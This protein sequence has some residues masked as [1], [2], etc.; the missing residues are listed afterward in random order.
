MTKKSFRT[1]KHD[2]QVRPVYHHLVRVLESER[3][4]RVPQS[5][6]Q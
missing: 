1:S 6:G 3:R 5:A 4:A 2:L